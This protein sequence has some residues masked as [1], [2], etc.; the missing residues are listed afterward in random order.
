[1]VLREDGPG[2]LG[3]IGAGDMKDVLLRTPQQM[4][5]GFTVWR[6]PTGQW[7]IYRPDGTEIQ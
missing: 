5:T 2:G 4:E 7:H 6:D 3:S 1:M